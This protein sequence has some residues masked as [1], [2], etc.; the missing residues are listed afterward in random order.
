M[1]SG[2]IHSSKLQEVVPYIYQ[3]RPY[4]MATMP[5][6]CITRKDDGSFALIRYVSLKEDIQY[7]YH[8]ILT[9]DG[10]YN[11]TE[12]GHY[13]NHKKWGHQMIGYTEDEM[14]QMDYEID[15]II[16]PSSDYEIYTKNGNIF[17]KYKKILHHSLGWDGIGKFQ[18]IPDSNITHGCHGATSALKPG[19]IQSTAGQQWCFVGNIAD[20]NDTLFTF[21]VSYI[22]ENDEIDNNLMMNIQILMDE[23]KG[24]RIYWQFDIQLYPKLDLKA[25]TTILGAFKGRNVWICL[26]YKGK[27]NKNTDKWTEYQGNKVI[28]FNSSNYTEFIRCRWLTN[29]Q[30][31]ELKSQNKLPN[32]YVCLIP[33]GYTVQTWEYIEEERNKMMSQNVDSPKEFINRKLETWL[34]QK[35]IIYKK[36]GNEENEINYLN[37]TESI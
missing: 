33:P 12:I 27:G 8:K 15:K 22:D 1:N 37:I 6:D 14:K 9:F 4:R 25:M 13:H 2:F 3:L 36:R 30:I 20:N 5:H 35:N 26:V 28:F 24:T 11:Y 16:A 17:V 19:V 7:F 31:Q 32:K 18:H 21:I 10:Y 34:K 29:K 23:R